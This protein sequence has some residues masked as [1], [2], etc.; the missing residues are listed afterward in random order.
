MDEKEIKPKVVETLAEDMARVIGEDRQ[1]LIKKIIHGEEENEKQK[2]ELS[3]ESRKNKAYMFLSLVLILLGLGTLVYFYLQRDVSIVTVDQPFVPFIFSD[4]STTLEI[5]DLTKDQIAYAVLN[6]FNTAKVRDGGVDAVY[7]SQ[8]KKPIGLRKFITFIEGN[9][10]PG[11]NTV[12]VDDNFL[13]GE[14]KNAPPLGSDFFMI[15][16]MRNPADIFGSL[17]SWEN[18]MYF[19]LHGFIGRDISPET[20]YLLTKNF[21]DGV[22]E[23]KNARILYDEKHNPVLLYVFATDNYVILSDTESAA[24]EIMLRLAAS[25]I[26]K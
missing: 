12:F 23:N 3:P 21:E 1:G 7:F 10:I 11:S 9:F 6:E 26:K 4:K 24:R 2:Q 5:K 15:L 17:R 13:M 14:V 19:D 25:Q 20:S 22:I 18:K 8:D 16:K